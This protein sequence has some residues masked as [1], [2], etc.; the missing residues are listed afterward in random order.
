MRKE[1]I[2]IHFIKENSY[3]MVKIFL[4]QIVMSFFGT[5][6]AIATLRNPSLLLWSSI[7]SIAI[8][9]CVIYTIG[10]DIG[11]RDKIKIDG[12]RM[13]PFPAKGVLIALGGNAPNL[14]LALLMGLGVL[15]DTAGS[16]VMSLV[17]NAIA[18]LINGAFL[19]TIK[20]LEDL[21]I[22]DL[23]TGG[24]MS[25]I[26]WWF[27]IMVIPSLI[28]VGFAYLMGSHDL[29]I[30]P[31]RQKPTGNNRPNISDKK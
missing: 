2:P 23:P 5:M 7:L 1:W 31:V 19:G 6:L 17:C 15:I 27:I 20:T 12:G 21:L 4:T 30:I 13:R 24:T 10:W 29:R 22:A 11:A 3:N 16:Q 14:I 25:H 26:W 18:R 8:Q 9:L 28:A